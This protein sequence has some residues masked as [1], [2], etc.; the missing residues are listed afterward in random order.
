MPRYSYRCDGC[1]NTVESNVRGDRVPCGCGLQASR[2]FVFQLATPFREHFN[3]ATG[4]YV[5]SRTEFEDKLKVLSETTS[6]KTGVYTDYQ[7]VDMSDAAA[8]GLTPEDVAEVTETRAK[9]G[10]A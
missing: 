10:A 7:P 1:G 3:V 2:R 5:T 9:A 4:Q 8:C 6:E